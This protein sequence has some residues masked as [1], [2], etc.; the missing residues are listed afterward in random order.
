MRGETM[1]TQ[2]I[3]D[4]IDQI[5]D[6]LGTTSEGIIQSYATALRH[7]WAAGVVFAIVGTLL[8]YFAMQATIKKGDDWGDGVVLA[9][10]GLVTAGIILACIWGGLMFDISHM[11][12]PEAPA[13]R[14]FIR[15]FLSH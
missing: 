9:G 8:F 14:L 15:D 2:L 12:M 11:T 7:E 3:L 5:A 13:T 6:K 1:E 4:K 10:S